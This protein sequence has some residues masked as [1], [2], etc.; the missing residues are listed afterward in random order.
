MLTAGG[1]GYII[2]LAD[3]SFNPI[4]DPGFP[5]RRHRVRLHRH[6]L[7]RRAVELATV[8]LLQPTQ[9]ARVV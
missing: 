4:T 5:G 1:L 2:N 7:S 6:V 3:D 8:P 9:W